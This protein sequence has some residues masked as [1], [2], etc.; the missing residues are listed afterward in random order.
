MGRR[1]KH[2]RHRLRGMPLVPL[3]R[4]GRRKQVLTKLGSEDASH[5]WPQYLPGGEAVLFTA[6]PTGIGMEY[7]NIE[8]VSLK[9]GAIKVV[10]REA[11]FGRYLP[12]GHLVLRPSGRCVRD[13]FRCGA[14]GNARIPRTAARGR[15]KR[16][17]P[18]SGQF[19]VS[20]SPT[21][22]ALFDVAERAAGW[23]AYRMARRCR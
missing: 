6:A 2:R 22:G 11:Y 9:T 16:S 20:T 10:Q 7:A 14:D 19:D 13:C 23:W 17:M 5:R 1:W 15:G 3:A 4:F 8:V 18:G 21:R 12:S